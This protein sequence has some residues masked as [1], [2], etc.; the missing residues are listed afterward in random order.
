METLAWHSRNFAGT[1][2]KMSLSILLPYCPRTGTKWATP[3]G[4]SAPGEQAPKRHLHCPMRQSR[5]DHCQL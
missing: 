5:C 4:V 3:H 1:S 2:H